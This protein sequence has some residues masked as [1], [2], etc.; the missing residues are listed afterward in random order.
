MF[1]AKGASGFERFYALSLR[2]FACRF[3][4]ARVPGFVGRKSKALSLPSGVPV[5]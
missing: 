1:A 4:G 5:N 3:R 2:F